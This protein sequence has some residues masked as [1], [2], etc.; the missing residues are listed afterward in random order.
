MIR[1]VAWLLLAGQENARFFERRV[2][3][4]LTKR[5]LGCH[6]QELRAG[7][8]SFADRESML[9]GGKRGPS[10]VPGNAEASLLMHTVRRTGDIKMPP[11]PELP[12]KEV[13]TLE[14]WIDRGAPW[15]KKPLQLK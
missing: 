1:L 5:C 9:K 3:P 4:I 8:V 7:D 6:S 11:G 13:R 14:E 12:A 15:G 2:A 10:I